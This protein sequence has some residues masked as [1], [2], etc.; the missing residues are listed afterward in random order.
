MTYRLVE[1][2]VN[3]H[4]E[5]V[6]VILPSR[7][8]NHGP[9]ISSVSRVRVVESS[10][11]DADA[12]AAARIGQ[13]RSVALMTRDDVVNIHAALRAMEITDVRLVVRVYN[14]TLANR[15]ESML[16]DCA[17]LSD[18]SI[19]SPSFVAAALGELEPRY[20][21]VADRTLY[22]TGPGNVRGGAASWGLAAT[23]P[24]TVLLPG[25]GTPPD[26]MLAADRPT[27]QRR[28]P[29]KHRVRRAATRVWD[30]IREIA[31]RKLRFATL[32]LIG[33]IV[34]GS[35]LIM[36][37]HGQGDSDPSSDLSWIVS[38]YIA[39]LAAAG[40]IDPDLVAPGAEKFAHAMTA[41]AG[42]LLIPVFTASIVEN[43]VG[44]RLAVESGRL[45][46]PVSDHIIVVGLGNVGAQV[47]IQLRDLGVPVVAVERDAQSRGVGAVRSHGIPV[48]YGDASRRETLVNAQVR[49]SR[50]VVAVTSNDIVNLEAALHAKAMRPGVRTV[51][52]LFEDD[53]AGRV[54]RHFDMPDSL[55]VAEVAAPDFASAMTDRHVKGTIR[56]GS[57]L[58]LVGEVTVEHEAPLDG[59]PVGELDVDEH[60]RVLAVSRM[61]FTEWSP[62]SSRRLLAGDT[63]YA[64]ATRRGLSTLVS[65]AVPSTDV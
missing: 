10:E 33:V 41:G 32:A 3:R 35:F 39:V 24:E 30:E 51:L 60:S 64:L 37:F 46:G 16:G 28:V 18:A 5:T 8:E 63:V 45:R 2:L 62:P 47:A 38:A 1:E 61:D 49:T 43:M 15:V 54:Q 6:T 53:M 31:D 55:S 20:V 7:R 42:A 29:S 14:S 58:L 56:V 12:F 65:D 11:L 36:E 48:V 34:L 23:E 27:R 13:A 26:L 22:V 17:L 52:R 21:K 25:A 19:A 40:G 59:N 44:R 9:K 50:A 4:Q 57:Y